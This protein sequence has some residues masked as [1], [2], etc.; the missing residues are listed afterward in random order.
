MGYHPMDVSVD[1]TVVAGCGVVTG[2]VMALSSVIFA[3]AFD[4]ES[5]KCP[6]GILAPL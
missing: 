3:V 4:F 5:D 6:N 1:A 2:V